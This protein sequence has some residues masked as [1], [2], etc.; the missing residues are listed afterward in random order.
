MQ[1]KINKLTDLVPGDI[2]SWGHKVVWY[3]VIE[4][5][6]VAVY[7]KNLSEPLISRNFN[8]GLDD[9]ILDLDFE[10]RPRVSTIEEEEPTSRYFS[11]DFEVLK[12]ENGIVVYSGGSTDVVSAHTNLEDLNEWLRMKLSGEIS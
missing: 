9:Y 10:V 7:T 12:D 4:V 8:K 1:P 2:F 3:E 11:F 6:P 5:N